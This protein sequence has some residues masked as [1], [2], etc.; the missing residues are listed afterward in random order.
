VLRDNGFK[1]IRYQ[2]FLGNRHREEKPSR[3][4]PPKS[5]AVVDSSPDDLR[6]R[7]AD[8]KTLCIKAIH[9]DKIRYNY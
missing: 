3:G 1:R 2:G 5:P 4:G 7:A 8:L 6:R 9:I